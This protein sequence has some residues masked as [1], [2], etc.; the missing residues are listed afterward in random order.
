MNF[1]KAVPSGGIRAGDVAGSG[2]KRGFY[3][4]DLDDS[5]EGVSAVV[6]ILSN[7]LLFYSA[8]YRVGTPNP[9]GG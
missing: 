2:P 9:N 7:S 5:D 4:S 6:R 1:A 3:L 8:R